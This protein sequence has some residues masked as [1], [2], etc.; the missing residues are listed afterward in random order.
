MNSPIFTIVAAVNNRQVL[1]DNLLRSPALAEGCR[2]QIILK[3]GFASASLAYNS[4]ID[5]AKH[6]LILFIHQDVFLPEGWFD[7]VGDWIEHLDETAPEWGV[8][9]AYGAKAGPQPSVG[10]IYT[11]GL[12]YHGLAI[13][14]PEPV[15]TLDEITLV[16]RKS[17]GLRFDPQLPHFHMYGV[18]ICLSARSLG[19]TNYALPALCVHNTEQ[20]V[21]L[22]EEFYRCYW[23]VKQKWPGFLPIQTSCIRM[24]RFDAQLRR[25]RLR[26][27][28]DWAL[29]MCVERAQRM[30]D[31]RAVLGPQGAGSN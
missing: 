22:P 4:A 14:Q 7:A 1:C 8:A 5:E 19:K 24:S 13:Q 28:L 31:P 26:E 15:E 6:D 21:V 9:G 30:E 12:G 10:Q 18:D 2:H 23:Y 3:E 11:N 20:I 17:S 16:F 27:M 25:R 29:P